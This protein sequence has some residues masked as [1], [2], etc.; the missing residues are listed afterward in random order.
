MAI[1]PNQQV[2]PPP[3]DS[4]SKSS[5][6]WLIPVV[7]YTLSVACLVWVY[8]GYPWHEELPKLLRVDW[9]W[10]VIGMAFEVLT[11]FMQG[12]RWST[13]L[14]PVG[15]V[16]ILRA[17][18]AVFVA[19]F[20]NEVLPMR[21]GEFLRP[22]LI[23]KWTKIRLSLVFCSL[24]LE[25]V[26]DGVWLLIGFA[27]AVTVIDLPPRVVLG[28]QVLAGMVAFLALILVLLMYSR[29]VTYRL[30]KLGRGT[31]KITGF[32]LGF[33][34]LGRS[35]SM[36]VAFFLS[37]FYLA[38][39]VVPI[40]ALAHG[41][42]VHLSFFAAT[43]VLII[44][45]LVTVIP[46]GPGN[47]GVTQAALVL[48]LS[49]FGVDRYTATGLATVLFAIITVPLV[50]SGFIA[51]LITGFRLKDLFGGKGIDSSHF[52]QDVDIHPPASR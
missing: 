14:S 16:G 21:P 1:T 34:A 4:P 22:L 26:M 32:L 25:R 49:L 51:F 45:R 41:Y 47:V 28:A 7:G 36:P 24:V 6:S 27:V 37:F 19:I 46:Q 15:D 42:G 31:R 40:Y 13:V 3:T 18:R 43:T 8:W 38:F 12:W 20:L 30:I 2:P 10:V 5:R 39:Q 17:T 11:Y 52:R 9:H 48:G 35:R 33:N 50:I 29:A 23:A 44:L